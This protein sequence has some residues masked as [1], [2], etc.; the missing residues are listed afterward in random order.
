MITMRAME[1]LVLTVLG[2][3][4]PGVVEALAKTIAD[5]GASWEESRMSHLSGYF[6]GLLRVAVPD[7]KA[8]GL[9]RALMSLE[10]RGLRV[11]IQ[12][13]AAVDTKGRRRVT[14]D[15]IGG[16]RPGIVKSVSEVLASKDVNVESLETEVVPA[17]DQGRPLFKAR[18]EVALPEGLS[19]RDLRASLE[20]ISTDLLVDIELRGDED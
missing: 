11:V 4:R 9:Y 15:L 1:S 20:A 13:G 14:L 10:S 18:G 19:L 12:T 6:A 5:H 3:D 2:P 17:P 16:D 8:A 7:E